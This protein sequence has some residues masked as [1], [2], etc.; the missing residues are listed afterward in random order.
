M[1]LA[2]EQEQHDPER[3]EGAEERVDLMRPVRQERHDRKGRADSVDE[4]HRA[5]M[6]QP[7]IEEAVVDV[8]PVGRERRPPVQDR[9]T[10]T[11][12]VSMIGTPR[13]R[14]ATDD[15][16]QPMIDRIASV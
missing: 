3:H 14:S 16:G 6:A 2:G 15:L 12:N 9:R 1:R 11:Q 13:T 8:A 10:I 7:E 4:Q 5:A